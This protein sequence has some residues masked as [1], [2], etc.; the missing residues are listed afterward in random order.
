MM[1]M[2]AWNL[3]LSRMTLTAAARRGAGANWQNKLGVAL[4]SGASRS[5]S[6]RAAR[7]VGLVMLE[8]ANYYATA[9]ERPT[10][11][12]Q[13]YSLT[14]FMIPAQDWPALAGDEADLDAQTINRLLETDRKWM[15]LGRVLSRPLIQPHA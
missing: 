5:H 9:T 6:S 10:Y 8:Q 14:P 3:T 7:Y 4:A 15:R 2:T 13:N 1:L 11:G 12:G